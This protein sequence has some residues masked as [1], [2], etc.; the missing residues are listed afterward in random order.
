MYEVPTF[1]KLKINL[2]FIFVSYYIYFYSPAVG[3]TACPEPLLQMNGI[4]NGDRYMVNDVVSFQCEP[5]YTLQVG[6]LT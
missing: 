4:K 2:R 6:R 3:L 5:G 1:F